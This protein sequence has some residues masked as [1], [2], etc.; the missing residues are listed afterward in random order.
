MTDEV[1]NV[2]ACV[3]LGDD[4]QLFINEG[5]TDSGNLIVELT[6]G[7]MLGLD[8]WN[9]DRVGFTYENDAARATDM[10]TWLLNDKGYG[11]SAKSLGNAVAVLCCPGGPS[12]GPHTGRLVMLWRDAE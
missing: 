2:L 6:T 9:E 10:L 4:G 3:T 12:F 5:N 11:V 1:E 8:M 7:V